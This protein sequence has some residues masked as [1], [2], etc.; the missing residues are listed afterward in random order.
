MDRSSHTHR[1]I[2]YSSVSALQA[3]REASR[4]GVVPHRKGRPFNKA[5]YDALKVETMLAFLDPERPRPLQPNT[6]LNDKAAEDVRSLEHLASSTEMQARPC[7]PLF[8]LC[9]AC[10]QQLPAESVARYVY[11]GGLLSFLS[12]PWAS[13]QPL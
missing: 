6:V 9:R 2:A 12:A 11:A 1:H 8:A 5:E 7:F 13:Q 3:V 10:F 4:L